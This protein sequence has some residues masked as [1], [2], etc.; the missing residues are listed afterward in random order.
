MNSLPKILID[1]GAWNWLILSVALFVLETIVPGVHFVWFGMAAAV[2]GALALSVDI[3]W[4]WQLVL[5][6]VIAL[7]T[8]FFVRRYARPETHPSDRPGLNVRGSYYIG[9]LVTVEE[10]IV[11]GRGRVKVGDSVWQ[12]SGPDMAKG[13][14]A[15]VVAADGTVLVVEATA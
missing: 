12:A 6:G 14:Q 3:A 9:R 7:S 5:F 13:T 2:V 10:E 15:K 11:N 8:V 4:Q 1:L